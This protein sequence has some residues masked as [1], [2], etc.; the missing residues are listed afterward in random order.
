L[1]HLPAPR[2]EASLLASARSSDRSGQPTR[3]TEQALR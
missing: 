2:P 3:A 1:I